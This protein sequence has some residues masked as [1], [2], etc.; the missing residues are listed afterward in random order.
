MSEATEVDVLILGG[1]INGCGTFRDLCAQGIDCLLLEKT[2][3][4]AG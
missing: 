2:D 1:G 4:C 3:F